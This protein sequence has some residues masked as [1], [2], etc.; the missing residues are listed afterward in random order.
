MMGSFSDGLRR[1][2]R[3]IRQSIPKITARYRRRLE[4]RLRRRSWMEAADLWSFS[5]PASDFIG[6]VIA[7]S[8]LDSS[9]DSAA[10]QH[11]LRP[12]TERALEYVYLRTPSSPIDDLL[13]TG[14]CL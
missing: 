2:T 14:F 7:L 4:H 1:A 13:G 5:V 3:E 9:F 11:L 12:L 6:T 8:L 10:H